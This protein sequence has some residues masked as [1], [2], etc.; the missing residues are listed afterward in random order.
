MPYTRFKIQ[1]ITFIVAGDEQ[2]I[3]HL[4]IDQ[5]TRPP[6]IDGNWERDDALFCAVK[7]QLK[8]YFE[9]TRKQFDLRLNPTGTPFQ[10]SVWDKLLEIPYG[11]LSTYKDLAILLE[12]PKA[13]RAVGLANNKNPIPIIIPCHRVVGSKG[14]MMGFAH[15]V[16]L[17]KQLIEMESNYSFFQG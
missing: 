17:K 2:G 9:G 10:K 1:D 7:Q 8:E 3:S 5:D 15:G 12:K 16:A 13:S 4:M 14:K 6:I 11:K